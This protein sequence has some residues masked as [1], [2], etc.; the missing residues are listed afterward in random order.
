[1]SEYTLSIFDPNT[2][3]P[4]RA[5]I[6]GLAL[7]LSILNADEAPLSW[8]VTEDAVHLSWECSDREAVQWVLE[9][10]YQVKDGYLDVPALNLA[11]AQSQ[12]TFTSG[13][14]T[15][16]LQHS[17]QRKQGA[18]VTKSFPI[19]EGQ[20]E[21]NIS[22]RPMLDCYYTG[23]FKEAF[24]SKGVFKKTIPLKG[25]HLPGLVE[26]FANGAY[27]ESRTGYLA[28]LFL[29]LACGYYQL[30]GYRSAVVIPEVTNLGQWVEQR[31][32]LSGRVSQSL[33]S[34]QAKLLERSYVNYRATGAAEAALYFLLQERVLEDS[35]IFRVN[36]CEVYQLGKQ[37]WDGNQSY[38]KQAVYRVSVDDQVLEIYQSAYYLF[39]SQ[40]RTTDKGETWLAMSKVLPWIAGNLV[41]GKPWYTN[42]FEFRKANELYERK[43]LVKMTEHL[44][45]EEKLLF[46]SVSGAF[47][48]FR[49]KQFKA[50]KDQLKRELRKEEIWDVVSSS[51][52]KA[53]YQLQRPNTQRD[54]AKALVDFLSRHRGQAALGNGLTIYEWLYKNEQSWRQTRDLALLAIATYQSEKKQDGSEPTVLLDD[55][56]QEAESSEEGTYE[57]NA[58]A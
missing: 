10:T 18:A 15:T 14:A 11:D 50:R 22:F 25:H 33:T 8:E 41:A 17:Q 29:P 6:A 5:G 19:E 45:Q 53:I 36:Y 38:L 46:D 21:I 20:P 49:R 32:R 57:I 39:P 26:C 47:G 34:Q 54:F 56:S 16:F 3:L 31:Q 24:S 51:A 52:D 12:Y 44:S 35:Q 30:P 7:A 40:I 48:E 2:L 42:F 9:Q 27:Q 13:V 37:P 58:F 1:M 28:L 43:G 55:S 4:H 23:D